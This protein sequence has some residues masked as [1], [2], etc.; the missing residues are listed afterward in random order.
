MN[1]SCILKNKVACWTINSFIL[2][3]GMW[4]LNKEEICKLNVD[5]LEESCVQ[6]TLSQPCPTFWPNTPECYV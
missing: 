4:V 5:S 6:E 3:T 2:G 1:M